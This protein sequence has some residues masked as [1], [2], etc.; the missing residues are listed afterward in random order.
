M[1]VLILSSK[2]GGG[3][4]SVAHALRECFERHGESCEIM[5]CLSF[6]SDTVSQAV[7]HSH[8]FVY[9][10]IPDFFGTSY[11][12][13]ENND[14]LFQENGKARKLLSLGADD[15]G[16][17]ILSGGYD[18]VLCTHVFA[19][20]MLSDAIVKYRLS[21]KTAIIETDYTNTPGCTANQ[22][23]YHFVPSS[24]IREDLISR[25]IRAES[26]MVSGIP[27]CDAFYHTV[28]ASKAKELFNIS[29]SHKHLLFMCGSM[30][31]GPVPQIMEKLVSKIDTNTEITVVC[32]S[33]RLLYRQLQGKY[34]GQHQIHLL[35]YSDNIPLLMDSADV[36]LT[37]PGGITITEAAVKRL[38]LVLV[39]TVSG[40]EEY[41]L[42]TFL[43]SGAALTGKSPSELASVCLRL[44]SDEALRLTLCN[45]LQ[46][47]V[48]SND[49][50]I[51]YTQMK[52]TRQ[53]QPDKASVRN[54]VPVIQSS[55]RH[56]ILKMPESV[57]EASGIIVNGR[58]LKSFLFTTDL[59]IIR[60]CDAD[61]VFAV[62]PFT[63][64]QAISEA[65]IKAAYIPVFCGV[66]GGTTK[67]VRTVGLAKDAEGQGAM[68]IVLNAPISNPNLRAVAT[69]VDIPVI[70]TVVN[71]N[72]NIARRLDAGAAII[73]VAGAADT[74]KIVRHIRA[75]YPD[76]PIIASGGKDNESIRETILAG[77]NAIT[78]TPPSTKELF[79]AT[80]SKYRDM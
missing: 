23:D 70:I 10:R 74:P 44:L 22:M 59:A 37:K 55:L 24:E 9:R 76:V 19:A 43:R 42:N 71:E 40:C 78:Y 53:T 61:A 30:G 77:A 64:Q 20:M 57:Y 56:G 38:P 60:N 17:F 51:I 67:G 41:N 36:L 52:D 35:G 62:Y 45:A 73:N 66:G 13:T 50:E 33:N 54:T 68:G 31:S 58:R 32:G 4:N 69:A 39:N 46:T 5:D 18:T 72:T 63:P 28:E 47:L 21:V 6:I 27:V 14:T 25:G 8:N 75:Q 29:Q 11:E 3:H 79:R 16:H 15:L 34:A 49:R 1:R 65:I 26:V 7:S 2:N 80:M 48:E 12:W